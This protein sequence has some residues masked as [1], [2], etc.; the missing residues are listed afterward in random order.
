MTKMSLKNFKNNFQKIFLFIKSQIIIPTATL[1]F[2]ECFVPYCG[3]SIDF[4]INQ[5]LFDQLH[6]FRFQI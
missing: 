5:L 1:T 3:I 4:Y 2:K 6:K